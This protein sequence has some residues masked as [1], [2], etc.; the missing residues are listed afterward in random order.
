V[1]GVGKV[2]HESKASAATPNTHTSLLTL[3][4]D[5]RTLFAAHPWSGEVVRLDTRGTAPRV[6]ATAQTGG[7]P[8]SVALGPDENRLCVPLAKKREI[9]LLDADSL[10]PLA[11]F[12]IP[13]TPRAALPSTDGT[14]LFVADFDRDRVL[15]LNAAT[16][17]IE[18]ESDPINRPGCLALQRGELYTAS[19]R[20]GEIVVLNDQCEVL[21]RL[22]APAQLNQCRAITVGPDGLVYAPQTRSDTAVGG[23]MFDR[24][25]FPAIAVA[26]PRGDKVWIEHSPDLVVVPPHRPVEVAVDHESV[27]L[28]SAGSDDVLAIDR[29][30]GFARWHAQKV[31]LE[32]GGIMLDSRRRRLYVLT[33]TGQEIVTLDADTGEVLSRTRFAHD[34]TP[35]KIARGRYLFGTATDNRLTKDQWMSCAVCHPN[36]EEDGRQWD[37]GTGP[38]DTRSLRGCVQAAPLHFDAHLDEIEDTYEFTRMTMAGQWFVRP[39]AMHDLLGPS[40][41]GLD[42]DLD[43]LAAYVASLAPRTPP[44]PPAASLERIAAGREIFFSDETGCAVCHPPPL[45]TDSGTRHPDGR[46]VLH[47]VG[48]RP[49]DGQ[50]GPALDTPSLLELHRSDPYLHHG[51]ART[52]EEVFTRF[53]PAD[54]HGKTSHL[55]GQQIRALSEFLRY[56]EP[57]AP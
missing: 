11:R 4:R 13:G 7:E 40:N 17:E 28:A 6:V 16:G 29:R 49:P 34:P 53:N 46:L 39:D 45:Y 48:T 25:V 26:N 52:L 36:G 55:D 9:V 57:E 5:A 14:G 27:Y 19:F 21:R 32:P 42:P 3:T 30:T 43:A 38:L 54:R 12:S 18:G 1:R 10:D 15:R 44:E 50:P 33:V 20:T 56:L 35:A 51:R 23:R 37:L 41:A 24:S 47:D 8:C 22:A 2:Q 31:G